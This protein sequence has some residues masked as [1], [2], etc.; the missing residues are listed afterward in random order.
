MYWVIKQQ[1]S[2]SISKHHG[3]SPNLGFLWIHNVNLVQ[4]SVNHL[5]KTTAKFLTLLYEEKLFI[6]VVTK[7]NEC[8][9]VHSSWAPW[10]ASR[11][12]GEFHWYPTS[13]YE[14]NDTYPT[15][16]KK[17]FDQFVYNFINIRLMNGSLLPLNFIKKFQLFH[18]Q[19]TDFMYTTMS[20]RQSTEQDWRLD[21]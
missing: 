3:H 13:K 4:K 14:P 19:A 6:N 15:A 20:I 18:G 21:V 12:S 11:L 16:N 17:R 9:H 8:P 5:L 7:F 2:V 10:N 1:N